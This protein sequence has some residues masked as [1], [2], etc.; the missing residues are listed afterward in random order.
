M[1]DPD[2]RA[3]CKELADGLDEYM[4]AH[5]CRTDKEA[6]RAMGVQ[7]TLRQTRDAL[8]RWGTPANNTG[9]THTNA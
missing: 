1:T 9:G 8:A 4:E 5:P 3:L 6:Y 2:F 7:E